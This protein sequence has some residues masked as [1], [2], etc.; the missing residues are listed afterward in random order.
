MNIGLQLTSNSQKFN[1]LL[2]RLKS[3]LMDVDECKFIFINNNE[4]LKI[5]ISKLDVLLCY[6]ISNSTFN[7]RS[8]RLKWIHF[9]N[10][11]IEK[12]LFPDIINSKVVLSNSKGI[13][14][15]PVSEFVFGL[16]LNDAKLFADCN[17]FKEK[18]IWSQW[19]LAR[20]IKQLDGS[21]IG[22]IGYGSI[23]REIAKKAKVFG[24][25]IIATKRLQKKIS[26]DKHIKLLPTGM[27]DVLM[28]ESDYIII[29]CPLT[30]QTKNMINKERLSKMRKSAFII[31]VSRGD[32][33][34]QKVLVNML[35]KNKIR[36]AAL[37]VFDTEPLNKDSELFDLDNVF[38]SPHI[39]GNY[40]TYQIDLIDL[41]SD[42]LNRF[43]NGK[44]LLNRICKKR[45]Y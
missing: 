38:L 11:G 35:K 26:I 25:N 41:F 27:I 36:G 10:S 45:L 37:D 34:D 8:D 17:R 2:N 43:K 20:K 39:S 12:S 21:T 3:S 32:V 6:E 16:I 30:P 4:E 5:K 29:S 33:L 1:F 23:G 19:D 40:K 31:N 14:A 13:H 9:G 24:I 22:I 7:C 15:K 28:Q 42:N 18:K 44:N